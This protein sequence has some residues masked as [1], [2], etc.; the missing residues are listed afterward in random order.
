MGGGYLAYNNHLPPPMVLLHQGGIFLYVQFVQN[1]VKETIPGSAASQSRVPCAPSDQL[2]RRCFGAGICF[3]F[4][5]KAPPLL[6]GRIICNASKL[7]FYGIKHFQAPG[8]KIASVRFREIAGSYNFHATFRVVNT[9][10]QGKASFLYSGLTY[11]ISEGRPPFEG[12]VGFVGFVI[13]AFSIFMNPRS[14]KTFRPGSMSDAF[15]KPTL[16]LHN[17]CK[18]RL[19]IS[20][21]PF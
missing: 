18:S 20:V 9:L 16:S 6:L 17:R 13:W 3:K 15:S 7:R 11:T 10:T 14:T 2:V 12:F 5:I 19:L 4:C 21:K 8:D 1:V